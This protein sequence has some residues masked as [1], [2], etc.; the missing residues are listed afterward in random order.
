MKTIKYYGLLLL[1]LCGSAT[2][3]AQLKTD[4]QFVKVNSWQALLDLAKKEHKM[5]F[6]DSYFIG[7]HPCKQMDDEVFPL[8]DVTRLM[9]DNFV[10]VKIDFMV[11]EL[12]KALQVKYAVTG[13]PTFLILNEDGQLVSRFSGYQEAD[14]FQK[15]LA[16]AKVKAKNGA[17]MAGFSANLGVAHPDFYTQMFSARKPMVAQDMIN[18]LAKDKDVLKEEQAVPFL[19]MKNIDPAWNTYF[20]EHYAEFESKYGQDLASGKRAAIINSKLKGIGEGVNTEAFEKFLKTVRP[21]YSDDSWTYA[22]LDIAEGYYYNLHKDHKAFFKYAA[23]NFND[24]TNKIRYM[25]MY[26][27]QPKVDEEE[28]QLFAD[29]MKLVITADAP[30]EV[31]STASRIMMTQKDVQ[32][33]KIYAG[34]GVKKAGVLKKSDSYF[35]E[36]L[37]QSK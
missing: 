14:V 35:K 31:L 9:K 32:Q 21:Y 26:L 18:Y 3:Q 23:A 22:K 25:A 4:A 27:N 6:I 17:V 13:F 11:E 29:W 19:M 7:C 5:I 10:S 36:I 15:R 2:T 33:A 8:S 1:L 12:G 37:A 30:Y 20:L 24:D 16:E 28:K 34:W